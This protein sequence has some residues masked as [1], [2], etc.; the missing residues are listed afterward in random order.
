VAVGVGVAVLVGLAVAEGVVEAVG[1]RDG[2]SVLVERGVGRTAVTAKRV[3]VSVATMV[4]AGRVTVTSLPVLAH[5]VSICVCQPKT[6]P[7]VHRI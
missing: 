5:A 6:D 3:A 7:F 2:A 1:V 4:I